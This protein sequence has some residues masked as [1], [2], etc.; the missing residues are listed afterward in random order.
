MSIKSKILISTALL[1]ILFAI[2]TRI[3]FTIKL[4]DFRSSLELYEKEQLHNFQTEKNEILSKLE[5][6]D[7]ALA[8]IVTSQFNENLARLGK[9]TIFRYL[10]L[11]KKIH[12]TQSSTKYIDCLIQNCW[13]DLENK[14]NTIRINQQ[15]SLLKQKYGAD[16]TSWFNKIDTNVLIPKENQLIPCKDFFNEKVS[17]AFN[18]PAWDALEKFLITFQREKWLANEA[19]R[20][21]QAEFDNLNANTKSRM[22]ASTIKSFNDELER[23]SDEISNLSMTNKVFSDEILGT[24]TYSFSTVTFNR[25]AYNKI[26][27][28]V[29]REQWRTNSLYT[30]AKPYANCYGT[31]NSCNGWECSQIK[32]INGGQDVL[33]MVKNSWGEVIRH[34]YIESNNTY[35]FEVSNGQY[36]VFFYSGEGWNPTKVISKTPCQ[37]TG[38]F[39]FSENVT[40]DTY[41]SLDNQ[42]LTYQLKSMY[43]GNFSPQSS[44]LRELFQ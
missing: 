5:N 17:I 20:K 31:N 41:V 2:F 16:F 30:G 19:N 35:V 42:I 14:K 13:I 26:V 25:E 7:P 15:K 11:S 3:M 36:K 8:K 44:S 21:V 38:G 37:L 18:K 32:V 6:K 27:A 1:L 28:E 34:A 22:R 24:I 4:N 10:Y 12:Y 23:H 43:N 29:M 9:D 39:E 40:K 33:V